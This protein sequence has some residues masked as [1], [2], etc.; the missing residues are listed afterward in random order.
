VYFVGGDGAIFESLNRGRDWIRATPKADVYSVLPSFGPVPHSKEP[1]VATNGA[2]RLFLASDSDIPGRGNLLGLDLAPN[3]F[4]VGSDLWWNSGESGIGLTITHHGSGQIF[5]IWYYYD[6]QGRATWVSLPGGTWLDDRTFTGTL[7]EATGPSHFAGPFD[8]SKVK[9]AAVGTATFH[10]DDHDH[11]TFAY[12]FDG[13]PQGEKR[14]SRF[15]FGAGLG[16]PAINTADLYWNPSQSG[17]GVSISHQYQRIFAIWFVYDEEG[18][19]TWLS[20]SDATERANF[21]NT[22][23]WYA[24]ICMRRRGRPS[25][26]PTRRRA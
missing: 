11:A 2:G 18:R 4:F 23:F 8:P 16:S 3:A 7:F 22:T 13:G 12:R 5:A 1:R 19:P 10:F 17:W 21:T 6:A 25:A 26:G 9:Q 15:V 20:M 24:G 14:L